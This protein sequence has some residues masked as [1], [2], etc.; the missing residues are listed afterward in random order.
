MR[1]K[2][3]GRSA[4]ALVATV[5]SLTAFAVPAQAHRGPAADPAVITTWDAIAVRTLT[6]D[7]PRRRTPRSSNS[8][9]G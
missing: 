4:V 7:T 6:V 5:L 9:S 8:T 3:C 2:S 1:V